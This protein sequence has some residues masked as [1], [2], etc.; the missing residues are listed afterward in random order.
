MFSELVDKL[1]RRSVIG[2]L[3]SRLRTMCPRTYVRL[4]SL[5]NT[6]FA[7]KSKHNLA[8]YQVRSI[9]TFQSLVPVDMDK[10]FLEIGSDLQGKTLME[11]NERGFKSLIG[12]NPEF[13]K[14]IIGERNKELP[15]GCM[16]AKG[17]IRSID[18]P[19]ESFGSIFSVS[20]FEHLL[21]F[22]KCVSEM[23]RLLSLNGYVYAEFGP[24]WPSSLG[25]HVHADYLSYS[26]RHWDPVKN[27]IVNHSHLLLSNDEMRKQLILELEEPFVDEI[28]DWIYKKPY[29]NRMFFEDY[30]SIL[31]QSDFE[32]VHIKYDKEYVSSELQSKLEKK[33]PDNK[34][35]N[36]RNVEIIL[37]K[38]H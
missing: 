9:N 25:H 26:A 28:I 35:F 17:D 33:Y 19:D 29:I 14:K 11:L 34:I 7:M 37:K 4:R 22:E 30:M 38:S 10:P 12:I 8:R 36:V 21:D 16:L 6:V 32:I 27:P 31:E 20:V 1:I 23:Y 24:I 5:Y 13:D 2:S 3:V 15:E 18:M